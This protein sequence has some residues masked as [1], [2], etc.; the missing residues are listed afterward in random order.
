[1]VTAINALQRPS[2]RHQQAGELL[3]GKHLHSTNS[4]T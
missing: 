4:I 3:A 2:V 1:M